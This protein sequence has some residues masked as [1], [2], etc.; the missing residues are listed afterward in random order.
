M[1]ELISQY[2]QQVKDLELQGVI[3][4][5]LNNSPI[6][7]DLHFIDLGGALVYE[8]KAETGLG[9]RGRPPAQ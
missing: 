6:V 4:L 8:W 5:F 9:R 1:A 2:V 7:G 3:E